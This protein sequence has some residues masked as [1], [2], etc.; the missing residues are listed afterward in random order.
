MATNQIDV[1]PDIKFLPALEI[2]VANGKLAASQQAYEFVYM[3]DDFRE[4]L[5]FYCSECGETWGTRTITGGSKPYHTYER[6]NCL[7]CGGNCD[8]LLPFEW[9]NLDLLS[10]S[11]LAYHIIN[12]TNGGL[13]NETL[14]A[15]S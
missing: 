12:L 2:F 14:K 3:D 11:V 10:E 7:A 9:E 8:M 4:V 5:H 15:R 1:R 13:E 6:S